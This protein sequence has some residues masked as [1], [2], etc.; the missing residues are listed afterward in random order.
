MPLCRLCHLDR[1]LR[2]SHIVP[3]FLYN[4][5]Y[6][7][8]GHLMAINGLG[9]RGW[10]P[11]QKGAREYLFCE[12]CEQHFNEYC[13]K[14]FLA[15]WVE[16][17]PLPNPWNVEDVHWASFDYASF[18]LFHL[19]VLFRASV[20]TLPTFAEVSLGPHEERLRK[21]L[22][23]RNPG[24]Y[25]Q[26]PIFGHAVVHH[27]TKRLVPMVSQGVRSSL[28]GLR[29]YG[30][31]YGGVHWWIGVSS[32]RNKGFEGACLQPDGQMPFTARPW[33][34][35]KVVQYAAEVLRHACPKD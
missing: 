17:A 3:E 29:C 7:D 10:K 18:K 22:L 19:S 31:I 13:E 21:I 28:E 35:V 6:N 8:K 1:E 16:A 15:Q 20:S 14:R 27:K 25:W 30:M 34:E 9:N 11:L 33:N 26:Y 23:S 24:E 2:N 32:H 12:A 5:L 4:D